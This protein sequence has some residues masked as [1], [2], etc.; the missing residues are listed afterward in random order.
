MIDFSKWVLPAKYWNKLSNHPL[1]EWN[2]THQ[3]N[4][5]EHIKSEAN[6]KTI[7]FIYQ[8]PR[9]SKDPSEREIRLQ[10]SFAQVLFDGYNYK[11]PT[12]AEIQSVI[13]FLQSEFGINPNDAVCIFIETGCN[14]IPPIQYTS[15]DS[16]LIAY[17]GNPFDSIKQP[18][19]GII[20]RESYVTQTGVKIYGKHLKYPE[21]GLTELLRC[22]N[23]TWK[24]GYI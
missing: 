18:G 17:D 10:F 15:I 7:S 22:E 3:G 9:F 12:I 1:L 6:Y 16:S 13:Y 23:K 14:I 4:T 2:H 11:N 8:K 5:S 24:M 20:G 21:L 19:N